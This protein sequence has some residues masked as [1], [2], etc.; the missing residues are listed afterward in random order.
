MLL[1]GSQAHT[2]GTDLSSSEKAVELARKHAFISATLGYHPHDA[3]GM[4]PAHLKDLVQLATDPKVVA[5]GEI[6]LDF[7]RRRS[8]LDRQI[9]AF[10]KQIDCAKDVGLPIVIHCR[11]AHDKVIEILKKKGATHRGVIH[12]FSGDYGLALVYIDMGFLISIPGTVTYKNASTVQE[13][14]SLIPLDC[15]LVETDAPYLTPIPFRGKRNEPLYTV[16]TARKIAEL[17]SITFEELALQ[18][19]RNAVSLFNLPVRL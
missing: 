9:E 3:K 10:E 12:C 5:W 19:S 6:G 14:A 4:D 17:R 1:A 18:T 15:L 7:F 16:H 2:I 13:V 8:P 11:D